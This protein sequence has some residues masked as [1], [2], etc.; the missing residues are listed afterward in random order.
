MHY[1]DTIIAVSDM[2]APFQHKDTLKFLAAVKKKYYINAK[3]SKIVNLGDEIDA[4]ALSDWPKD[5]D[6]MSAGEEHNQ[7][8]KFLRDY[9]KLMGPHPF[10]ISNHM[11]RPWK[12]ALNQGIPR[13]FLKSFAEALRAPQGT[14][15]RD[16]WVFNGIMFEHGENVSGAGAAMLAAK[17]NLMSTVIG[18]Q[19]SNGGVQYYGSRLKKI[20][21]ANAGAMIDVDAY[22]FHYGK[23]MRGKPT[24]GLV[25][26]F[27][28]NEA[29]FVP[30]DEDAK[31]NWTGKLREVR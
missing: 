23:K 20:F 7:A 22:A 14:E 27:G 15:W 2:Q 29:V 9:F 3:R 21:G 5:P 25:V 26:C 18:H 12:K 30:L 1:F 11:I 17:A 31:G 6:G 4:H 24:L 19:H 8:L 28:C 13:A 10:C 16:Y